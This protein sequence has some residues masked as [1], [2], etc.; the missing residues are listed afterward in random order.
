MQ[1][2]LSGGN[3]Q[4][5]FN[6]TE[7][8]SCPFRPTVQP[9]FTIDNSDHQSPVIYWISAEGQLCI[10]DIDGCICNLVLDT[11]KDHGLPPTSLTTDKNNIY[12]SNMN[13]GKI[14]FIDKI[15]SSEDILIKDYR[16]SD[17]RSIKAIGKSLQPYPDSDCLM[18]QRAAYSVQE[19]SKSSS[20]ITIRLPEPIAYLGCEKYNLPA[21]L[22][23]IDIAECK[24]AMDNRYNDDICESEESI[25]Y[26][27]YW[28][29]FEAKNLK[30]Y[31]QYY[32]KLTLANYYGDQEFTNV[33]Q[34]GPGLILKTGAGVPTEPTNLNVQALTPTLAVINWI[35]PQIW[36]ADFLHYKVFWRL[37][38]AVN[39]M[40][41]TSEKSI[42]DGEVSALLESLLP[43]Q[44]YFVYVKAYPENFTNIYSKSEE[45]LLKMY[46]EPNNL[47]LSGVTPES[48][49][50]SWSPM[51]DLLVDYVLEFSMNGAEN[52][53]TVSQ[54]V[55]ENNR[56]IFQIANLKS[57]EYYKFKLILRYRNYTK[58]FIWPSDDRFTFQTLGMIY[59]LS[60]NIYYLIF[61]F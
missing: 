12:W 52:W 40:K 29:E 7:D 17:V 49:N 43:G 20:S 21:T 27:T 23:S 26:Q 53:E 18:P 46:P 19:I 60:K 28:K 57:K 25:K 3:V 47:I 41:P 33:D 30:S 38:K 32:F 55:L 1:S 48:L 35:P 45:K 10:A 11:D 59:H 56:L 8:C 31:T 6:H 51:N 34:Y 24:T 2:D 4:P 54:Y 58:D 61:I 14:H 37:T 22:Y 9:V 39:D 44:E 15:T 13:T 16:L 5:F 36:N 42:K 50:I